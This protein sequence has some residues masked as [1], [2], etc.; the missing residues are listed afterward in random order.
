MTTFNYD[1]INL[2]PKKCIVNSRSECDTTINLGKFT[3][4]LPIVPSNME[5]VIN[6]E[7]AIKLAEKN[8]FYIMHRFNINIVEFVKKMKSLSL[9]A[10]ISVG[11]NDDSYEV[12]EKLKDQDLIPDFITIDIA[13]GHSIL[14]EK[15][16]K[17]VKLNFSSFV[18]AGNV[19]TEEGT[20][21]LIDWGANAIKIG[22]GPGSACT[23]YYNTGFGTRDIQLWSA[24]CCAQFCKNKGIISIADGGITHICDIT[25]SLVVHIDLVMIGGMLAGFS[26]SPGK[27]VDNNGK[28]FKEF[29]EKF[30]KTLKTKANNFRFLFYITQILRSRACF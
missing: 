30:L 5:C 28:L 15:M 18:I 24:M 27:T 6:E 10:S 11:V 9:F 8:Y 16:L 14:M 25:K 12:L 7:L 13:H 2:I 21:D 19:C 3:F 1:D 22:I 23:T 26:D 29:Y 20:K 4:N 17:Y